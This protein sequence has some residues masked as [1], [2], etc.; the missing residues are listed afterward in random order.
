[1]GPSG[2]ADVDTLAVQ[3]DCVQKGFFRLAA[4]SGRLCVNWACPSGRP[5]PSMLP[6]KISTS[7]APAQ[8]CAL[9]S[10]NQPESCRVPRG[11][12]A[13]EFGASMTPASVLR[14]PEA[15]G[16]GAQAPTP[17]ACCG[18]VACCAAAGLAL[19]RASPRTLITGIQSRSRTS[20]GRGA[21]SVPIN[22]RLSAVDQ[23]L[24]A[25]AEDHADADRDEHQTAAGQTHRGENAEDGQY[26]PTADEH[27]V[28]VVG[29][30]EVLA[31]EAAPSLRLIPGWRHDGQIPHG[32]ASPRC[33]RSSRPRDNQRVDARF[34][35]DLRRVGRRDLGLAG[36]KG[37]N[38]GELI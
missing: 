18:T 24:N 23:Q 30:L 7:S 13:P 21:R 37:A 6:A 26:Q 17:G 25:A 16:P 27:E 38:L 36:G 3:P 20:R 2:S 31:L 33:S 15:A 11:T 5:S 29:L 12:A 8:P 28:P 19:A 35:V 4:T 10:T 34:V 14:S 32:T 9:R 1:M 22:R